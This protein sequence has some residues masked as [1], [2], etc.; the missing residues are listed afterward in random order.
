VQI[1][2]VGE[3]V[4]V[5]TGWYDA[6]G[7]PAEPST[8]VLT[9]TAADGTVTSKTKADMAGS[10]SGDG[11]VDDV[12]TF[13][14]VTL[15]EGATRVLAVGTVGS[16]EVRQSH[17]LL[18]GPA[19]RAGGPF[20][21]WCEWDDVVA[22]STTDLSALAPAVR[23]RLLDIATGILWSLD[24]RR[25]PGIGQGT[26]L[27]CSTCSGCVT[28]RCCCSDRNSIDLGTRWPVWGVWDV[29]IDGDTLDADEYVLRDRRF[30][31]RLNGTWPSCASLTNPDDFAITWA[32][33]R[34]PPVELRE[35]CARF[36]LEMAKSALGQKC[37]LPQRVTVITREQVTYT[38]LDSQK[39]IDEGRTGVYLVDLALKASKAGRVVAP[40][41]GTPISRQRAGKLG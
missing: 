15:A 35:A 11:T 10:S 19:S 1:I 20:A 8:I 28:P 33:G 34:M 12:W 16:D 21:P 31:E 5:V 22:L 23:E 30:L 4:P 18:V 2:D 6:D 37:D 36:V 40:G 7:G 17:I 41:M 27:I 9:I 39:F 25:Y 32:Y 26:R 29:V 3:T 24:G 38:I 13:D 14:Y